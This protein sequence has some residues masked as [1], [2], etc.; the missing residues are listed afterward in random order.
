MNRHPLD[1]VSLLFGAVFTAI[2]LVT[3]AG[4]G[5]P[6]RWFDPRAV[7]PLVAVLAG[8]WLLASTRRRNR[9]EELLESVPQ[10]RRTE[11]PG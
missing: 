6:L 2:G 7:L 5:V 9:D 8:L 1:A 4:P 3:L 11:G 10:D